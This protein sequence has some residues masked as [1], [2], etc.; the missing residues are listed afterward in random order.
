MNITTHYYGKWF[1]R[2]RSSIPL[3]KTRW[4]FPSGSSGWLWDVWPWGGIMTTE[5]FR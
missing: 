3:L 2:Y 5:D 4:T 1:S